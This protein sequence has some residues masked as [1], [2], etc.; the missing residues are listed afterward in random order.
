MIDLNPT[1]SIIT[2]TVDEHNTPVKKRR[3]YWV[4]KKTKK[5]KTEL[6]ILFLKE[7]G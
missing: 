4:D 3:I 6:T 5:Q 2:L 7:R 1:S